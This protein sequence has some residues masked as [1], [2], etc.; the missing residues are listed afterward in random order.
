MNEVSFT[1][2]RD[3]KGAFA[4]GKGS[5]ATATIAETIAPDPNI[6]IIAVLTALQD[7]VARIPGVEHKALT[8]IEEAWEEAA[9]LKPKREEVASLVKQAMQYTTNPANVSDAVEKLKPDLLQVV[10][11]VG[12]TWQSWAPMLGLG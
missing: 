11:W 1:A 5:V 10:A 7:A 12:G 6:D 2:G 3:N 4:T 8:R 9:K